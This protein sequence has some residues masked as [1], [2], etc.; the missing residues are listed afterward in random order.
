M[1]IP[2]WL[3]QDLIENKTNKIYKPK[4]LREIARDNIKFGDT[5]LIKD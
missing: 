5:Q 2:E 4:P 3:S 1:T